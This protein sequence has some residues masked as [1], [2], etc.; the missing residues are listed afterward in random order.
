[1]TTP[2]VSFLANTVNKPIAL[3]INQFEAQ[4]QMEYAAVVSLMILVVN[5]AVKAVFEMKKIKE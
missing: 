3:M 1:M 2:A 5:I 4:A